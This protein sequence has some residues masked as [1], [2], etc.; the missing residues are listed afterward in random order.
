MGIDEDE[1][2][3][4]TRAVGVQVE[5]IVMW[6]YRSMQMFG[7]DVVLKGSNVIPC[8]ELAKILNQQH[9]E[10]KE[11]RCKNEDLIRVGNFVMGDDAVNFSREFDKNNEMQPDT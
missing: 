9:K 1:S 6:P 10:I 11:L 8:T 4:K 2:T 7:A 3:E 5:P